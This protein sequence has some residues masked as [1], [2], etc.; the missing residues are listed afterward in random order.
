MAANSASLKT[1]TLA[2]HAIEMRRIH[3]M[4]CTDFTLL[5]F[6]N[7][8]RSHVLALELE[9]LDMRSYYKKICAHIKDL[10]KIKLYNMCAF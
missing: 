1:M 10:Y 9:M 5:Y 6:F 4:Y 3:K 7:N 8:R 2:Q